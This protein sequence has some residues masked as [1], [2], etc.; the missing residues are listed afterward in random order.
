MEMFQFD[1]I[2]RAFVVATLFSLVAPVLGMYLIL[3]RQALV[4][5]TL[6]HVSLMGVALGFLIGI[7][8][9]FVTII[10]VGGLALLLE[11]L[12]NIYKD[13]S[14][15][16]MAI[17]TASGLSAALLINYFNQGNVVSI[18]QYL[19]GSIV[20]VS[21]EQLILMGIMTVVVVGLA[22]I[23][24]KPMYTLIFDEDTAKV[25]GLPVR[26]MSQA[27]MVITG[28]VIAMMMPIVGSLLV[29]AILI[30]PAAISLRLSKRMG[31][32]VA[33][34]TVIALI[35]LYGGLFVSYYYG[36]PPGATI[37]GIYVII[38]VLTLLG[39]KIVNKTK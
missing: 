13:Y 6:S 32:V 2:R 1:F 29:S 11:Y 10:V 27:F 24:R 34:G 35:G 14:E 26:L 18:D 3:R 19:F 5:E 22:I 4:A 30:F 23:F 38:F 9:T 15:V 16:S 36:T 33:I 31:G 12:R 39:S 7:N 17:L 21:T 28:I 8:P 37:T 20:T 25:Q